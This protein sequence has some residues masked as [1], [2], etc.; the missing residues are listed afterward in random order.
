MIPPH[1]PNSAWTVDCSSRATALVVT[2]KF[3][4]VCPA[5]T[6]TVVGTWIAPLPLTNVIVEPPAGAGPVNVTVPVK[7]PPP[8][9]LP[10]FSVNPFRHGA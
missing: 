1:A 7:E 4:D 2:L 9:I 5:G 3:A 8:R 10:T 6:N